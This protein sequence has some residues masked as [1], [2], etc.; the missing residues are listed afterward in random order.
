MYIPGNL[1][2]RS[3]NYNYYMV[4]FFIYVLVNILNYLNRGTYFYINMRAELLEEVR[5]IRNNLVI[6]ADNLL[7]PSAGF[8][9]HKYLPVILVAVLRI[10]ILVN[11]GTVRKSL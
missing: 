2:I 11:Y 1:V 3:R 5:V 8:T 6:I 9:D 10:V 4:R 7:V